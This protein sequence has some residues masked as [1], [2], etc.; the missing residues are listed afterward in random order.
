MSDQANANKALVR[1]LIEEVLNGGDLDLIA[2][3]YTPAQASAARDWIEPFRASFPDV[4]MGIRELIAEGDTVIGHFAC[5]ATHTGTWL[6]HEP[7]GRRF[8]A[9]AEVG[10]YRFR[11]GKIVDSW[12]LEDN[13]ERL[14]QLGILA[15]G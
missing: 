4:H 6:G 15:G 11:D 14:I 7:T 10:V 3:L 2:E 8:T 1:R 5:S 9:I 12:M 13:L